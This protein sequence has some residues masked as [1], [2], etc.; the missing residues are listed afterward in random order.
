MPNQ[1]SGKTFLQGTL[2]QEALATTR[3]QASLD[4]KNALDTNFIRRGPLFEKGAQRIDVLRTSM[5]ASNLNSPINK[6]FLMREI[7]IKKHCK[8]N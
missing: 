6:D 3:G 5:L 2:R 7:A 4:E 8:N 1:T